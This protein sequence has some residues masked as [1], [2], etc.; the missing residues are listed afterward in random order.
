[1]HIK[2]LFKETQIIKISNCFSCWDFW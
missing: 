1:M 2:L